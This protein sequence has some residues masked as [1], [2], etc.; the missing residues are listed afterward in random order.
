MGLK[1]E[2]DLKY[3]DIK[4][5]SRGSPSYFYYLARAKVWVNNQNFPTYLNKR[6]ETIYIQTWH[7]T[8]LMC[9]ASKKIL[10]FYLIFTC[11]TH[12]S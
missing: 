7:G 9:L 11:Q 4:R 1:Q 8:P 2:Y 10:P 12:L 6:S 5:I 3:K